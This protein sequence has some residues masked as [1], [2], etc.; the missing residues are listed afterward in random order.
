MVFWLTR[1]SSLDFNG[2]INTNYKAQL[3][4]I[5]EDAISGMKSHLGEVSQTETKSILNK[6]NQT[7]LIDDEI[8]KEDK[9]AARNANETSIYYA[10]C[11]KLLKHH[12]K[13]ID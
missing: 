12:V 11:H 4:K 9:S 3:I 8:L 6:E 7:D 1:R 10:Q 13:V 5:I 2:E